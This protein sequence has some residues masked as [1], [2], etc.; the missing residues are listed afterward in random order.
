[1][2]WSLLFHT[3]AAKCYEYTVQPSVFDGGCSP[4]EATVFFQCKVRITGSTSTCEDQRIEWMYR[5]ANSS[6]PY[7]VRVDE[8]T[9]RRRESCNMTSS[10]PLITSMLIIPT[11]Q[12]DQLG[13]YWCETIAS[14]DGGK[15]NTLPSSESRISSKIGFVTEPCQQPV[16][17]CTSDVELYEEAVANR[18]ASGIEPTNNFPT[19]CPPTE[20]EV[21]TPWSTAINSHTSFLPLKT[22]VIIVTSASV[23]SNTNLNTNNGV[24]LDVSDSTITGFI[25]ILAGLALFI[26]LVIIISLICKCLRQRRKRRKGESMT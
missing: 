6:M 22:S 11:L 25:Y 8:R 3:H 10:G 18:C 13:Y 2:S 12:R 23:P 4:I 5:P 7:E 15:E 26:V 14:T 9:A 17:A 21:H 19:I 16:P 1:M 20:F 24:T